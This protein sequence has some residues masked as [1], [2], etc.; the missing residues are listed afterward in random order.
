MEQRTLTADYGSI[1]PG[2]FIHV[3]PVKGYLP[4]DGQV[5][6]ASGRSLLLVFDRPT[7]PRGNTIEDLPFDRFKEVTVHGSGPL[8]PTVIRNYKGKQQGDAGKAYEA[9]ARLLS[10]AG[11]RATSQSW[12]PGQWGAGAFILAVL[13]FFVLVGILVFIYMILVKPEGTLTVT[14]ALAPAAVASGVARAASEADDT[15]VCPRCAETVK[16]AALVCRYCG[17]EFAPPA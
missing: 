14:Y 10:T 12:A 2:D 3:T 9:E 11:Y 13:L 7:G 16:A 6:A 17:H 1:R 15:K 8:P 4:V 5:I